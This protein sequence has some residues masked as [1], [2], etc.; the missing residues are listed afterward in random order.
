MHG[1][2]RSHCAS[3]WQW[4]AARVLEVVVGRG[5]DTVVVGGG[6]DVG[7]VGVIVVVDEVDVVETTVGPVAVVLVDSVV[8]E[9]TLVVEVLDVVDAEPASSRRSSGPAPF[10][11]S[12]ALRWA[13]AG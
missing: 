13:S 1:S 12:S 4:L 3:T 8:E 11:R 6:G 5:A 2:P 10:S 7:V 9:V